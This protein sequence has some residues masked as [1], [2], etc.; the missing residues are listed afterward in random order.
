MRRSGQSL[1]VNGILLRKP[2]R[3]KV[4]SRLR[5]NKNSKKVI[6]W[7]KLRVCPNCCSVVQPKSLPAALRQCA[8]PPPGTRSPDPARGRLLVLQASAPSR[9]ARPGL[10]GSGL[11]AR[12]ASLTASS[13]WLPAGCLLLL[14]CQRAFV[15]SFRGSPATCRSAGRTASARG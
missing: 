12:L 1:R 10:P 3:R 8:A 15:A 6:S 2:P 14:R 5:Q 11:S 9:Q 13:G 7:E 4:T